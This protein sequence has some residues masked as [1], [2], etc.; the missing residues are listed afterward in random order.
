M[1]VM[2]I[3]IRKL[4][5]CKKSYQFRRD[6]CT[7]SRHP[8]YDLA[9]RYLPDDKEGIVV[10]IG[11]GEGDF[12][13][14]LSL[15]NRYTNVYLL[16][17]NNSTIEVLRSKFKN[18]VLYKVPE[19]LPFED[20]SVSYVH[21]SHIVEHLCHAELYSFLKEV[22]RVLNR[23]GVIVISTPLLWKSF[24]CD[25]TH[26]KPYYPSVFINY[27]CRKSSQR[28][29]DSISE[30]YAVLELVYRYAT[31][32]FE[33]WGSRHILFDFVIQC[34]RK[35]LGKLGIN[36]YVTNGYTLVLRKC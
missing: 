18:A 19:R 28:S 27:L 25:L 9:G 22:D 10:D 2:N 1:V 36:R 5:S 12:A 11:A 20:T 17:A 14:H 16:D 21:C 24:Y 26:I 31:V 3:L 8:F 13:E 34:S 32:C 23:G 4:N 33:E 7:T 30:N 15:A 29:A 35:L 6:Y